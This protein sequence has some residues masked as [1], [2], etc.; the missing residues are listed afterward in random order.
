MPSG[1]AKQGKL[2][3][4]TQVDKT[5]REAVAKA[6]VFDLHTHLYEPRFGG[7]LLRGVDEL[8]TYHYLIAES[9]RATGLSPKRYYAMSKAA[10]AEFI[11]DELFIKRSPVS[12]ATRGVVTTLEAYGLDARKDG[13]SGARKFFAGLSAQ[14]HVDLAFE[15]SGLTAAVMTNDPFNDS[16]RVVWGKGGRRDERFHAALRIDPLVIDLPGSSKKLNAW[17]YDVAA[18]FGGRSV[19]ELRR[20]LGDWIKVMKARYAAMSFTPDFAWPDET[21]CG[22]ILRDAVIPAC[23]EAGIPFALM[24]GVRRKIRPELADAG[25]GVGQGEPS[26]VGRL[27]AAFPDVTFLVTMLSRVDQHELCVTARKFSNLKIFGCWWFLNNPSIVAE[28]TAMRLELLGLTFVPQHS[29]A[30]IL[31]QVVYKWRHSKKVI[32]DV[33]AAKYLDMCDAGWRPTRDEIER[34]VEMLFSG[35][36][37]EWLG[38][39]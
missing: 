9:T 12:E 30:R 26:A 18:D 29:D 16:E 10:Q 22:R 3:T 28:M 38:L 35:N 27:C 14:E 39:K 6:P 31:D 13:L 17:G 19:A 4:R 23:R 21:L 24:I 15:T 36:A 2:L 5:V 37:K 25:D 1:K 20:F 8:V 7:L 11:W 33:L 34:D 32:A